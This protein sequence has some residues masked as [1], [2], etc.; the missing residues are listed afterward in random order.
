MIDHSRM[1]AELS[2]ILS[3]CM[4]VNDSQTDRRTDRFR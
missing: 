2:F 4:R 1:C 3:Q